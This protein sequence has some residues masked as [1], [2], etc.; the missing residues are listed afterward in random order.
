LTKINSFI[1]KYNVSKEEQE[2]FGV[3]FN[4]ITITDYIIENIEK[5]ENINIIRF[6]M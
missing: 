6:V 3:L 1:K 5:P 4:I 2:I